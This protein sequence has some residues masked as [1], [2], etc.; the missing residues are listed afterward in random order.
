ME[1]HP[2][3]PTA[4][5]NH[6]AAPYK[7]TATN[8][9]G[10]RFRAVFNA[11][12]TSTSVDGTNTTRYVSTIFE[13]EA[14]RADFERACGVYYPAKVYGG[15]NRRGDG[16][17]PNTKKVSYARNAA[18]AR[19]AE[20]LS[21]RL[22][23]F[24]ATPLTK[25]EREWLGAGVTVGHNVN[26]VD[27]NGDG[28]AFGCPAGVG[29]VVALAPGAG[30]VWVYWQGFGFANLYANGLNKV[31]GGVRELVAEQAALV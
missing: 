20:P 8:K 3:Y 16:M 12:H 5:V 14:A 11:K 15:I 18:N 24:T 23:K 30:R 1:Q 25:D 19:R 4:T 27:G 26:A 21:P 31:T 13:G 17:I 22:P 28:V 2:E 6:G 29:Y 9:P 10:E 7:A